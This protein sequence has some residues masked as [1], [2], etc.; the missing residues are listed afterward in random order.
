M[1]GIGAGGLGS[2][3]YGGLARK[4]IGELRICDED[5]VETSNLN[6]QVYFVADLYKPKALRLAYNISHL[7]LC[8]ATFAGHRVDFNASSADILAD[9]VDIAFVGVDNNQS[10]AFASRYFRKRRI[11]AIFAGVNEMADYGYVFVQKPDEACIG[12][13]FP[14]AMRAAEREPR[15]CTASPAAIDILQAI[16]ALTLYA[17]D[18]LVMPKRYCGW[19]FRSLNLTGLTDTAEVATSFADCPLCSATRSVDSV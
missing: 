10:R 9:A 15:K 5:V 12:C 2:F 4:G 8:D 17:L 11:P 18:C 6:R 1:L 3:V 13:V 16:G 7:S 14:D 19:T